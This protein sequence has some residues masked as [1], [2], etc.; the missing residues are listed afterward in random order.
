MSDKAKSPGLEG[1]LAIEG[2]FKDYRNS[3]IALSLTLVSLCS[4]LIVWANGL[5]PSSPTQ[6]T[7]THPCMHLAQLI[8]LVLA[9]FSCLLIQFANYQGYKHEA[10]SHLQQ[11]TFSKATCWFTCED[12]AVYFSIS[13]F[14]AGFLCSAYLFFAR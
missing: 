11:S 4:A 12:F 2:K 9:I 7:A 3:G 14:V 8:L 6:N 5:W 1:H 13:F 10:R